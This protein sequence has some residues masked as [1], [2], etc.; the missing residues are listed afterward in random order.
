NPLSA[1]A[2]VACL[3]IVRDPAVQ[4]R[5]IATADQLREGFRAALARRGVSGQVGGE[6]SLAPV[7]F[8]EP[9]IPQRKL[10][11]RF[12]AAMQLGGVDSSGFNFIVSATHGPAEVEQTVAALDDALGMLQAEG[13]L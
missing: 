1:A 4:R 5:A 11:H 12:R 10:I 2:G 7:S 9:K 3:E 8:N 13:T 6:V